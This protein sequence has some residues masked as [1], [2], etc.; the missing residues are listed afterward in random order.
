M[1]IRYMYAPLY[2]SNGSHEISPHD[3][4]NIH[5][6]T[7][8]KMHGVVQMELVDANNGC[9]LGICIC[10]FDQTNGP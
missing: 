9:D 7:E 10:K 1:W 3:I 6:I 5:A 2:A 4:Y 8:T